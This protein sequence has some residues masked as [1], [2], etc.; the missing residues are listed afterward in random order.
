MRRRS[1]GIRIAKAGAAPPRKSPWS[2][3]SRARS[4]DE[5]QRLSSVVRRRGGTFWS[6]PPATYSPAPNVP[7]PSQ[8]QT[9]FQTELENYEFAYDAV[10]NPST[11]ADL[12]SDSEW[13]SSYK[14]RTRELQYDDLYRV[15]R[16]DYGG[17]DDWTSPFSPENGDATDRVTP[18]PHISFAKRVATQTF[19]YDAVGNTAATDDDA[20]GFYDRSLGTITNG[21]AS[22]GP[23]QVKGATQPNGSRGGELSAAYDVAGNLVSLAVRRDGPC[24]PTGALCSQRFAYDWDEVGQLTRARRWDVSAPGDAAD[25]DPAGAAAADLRYTYAGGE[26]VLKTAADASGNE[27]HTV[28]VFG[29]LELRR[30]RFLGEDYERTAATEVPY[31][32]ANG[33]RLARVYYAENDLPT[34]SSG[35]QHVLLELTDHLG[36]SSFVIDQATSELVEATRYQAYGAID[37]DY[38]PERWAAYRD[39]YRF[40]GKEDDIEVGLTYFGARFYSPNL[41]RWISPD[42]LALHEPGRADLNLYAYV[43]GRTY[44]AVDP[45]GLEPVT[46]ALL[47]GAI[48]AVVNA[49]FSAGAQVAQNGRVDWGNVGAA[50]GVGFLSGF[51]GSG[52]GGLVGSSQAFASDPVLGAFAGGAAGGAVG[53]GISYGGNALAGKGA[54]GWGALGAIAIGS[55]VGGVVGGIGADMQRSAAL[56]RADKKFLD[57][58]DF[59]ISDEENN[60]LTREDAVKAIG[61]RARLE[62]AF[63]GREYAGYIGQ[64]SHGR[65]SLGRIMVGDR[66]GIGVELQTMDPP[67]GWDVGWWHTHPQGATAGFS[68]GY[69]GDPPGQD[70]GFHSNLVASRSKTQGFVVLQNGEIRGAF[71]S[72]MGAPMPMVGPKG[73]WIARSGLVVGRVSMAQAMGAWS[74]LAGSSSSTGTS[75]ALGL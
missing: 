11:I 4:T 37:A 12:R 31:L 44:V 29:S 21:S 64:N 49:A 63:T 18:S 10:D 24:L 59:G 20:H 74:A 23:Y 54:S 68:A 53:S 75:W 58:A 34:L 22:A 55:V 28:Y 7:G 72:N 50:A 66:K 70:V 30:A 9:V 60:F 15:T 52:V 39:D 47:A 69:V 61:P 25:A 1:G 6:A 46:A 35:H 32:F 26:R 33:V 62:T 40:T 42:P 41:N 2:A 36:S 71:G 38:R 73:V 3:P 19:S 43:N 27:L 67:D 8:A 14:P 17:N 16:T 48:S 56:A 45:A 51:A 57:P 13:P 65:W 5:R